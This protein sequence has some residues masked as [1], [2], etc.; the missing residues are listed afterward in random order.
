MSE[1]TMSILE[2]LE[3]LR[4][5]LLISILSLVPASAVGWYYREQL[6]ALLTEPVKALDQKLVYLAMTEAFMVELKLAIIAGFI[7]A[8]PV[9]FWQVWSFILPALQTHERRYLLVMVPLSVLLFC[10]GIVFGYSTVFRFGL[11][12]FLGFA[13]EGLTP[14]LSLSKYLTF[15]F[16]FLLPFGLM[17]ELPLVMFFLAKIGIVNYR[18]LAKNRK[19][20][21][22]IIFIISAVAT[23]TTDL[24]TQAAMAIPM[25]VLFEMSIWIVRFVRP[26]SRYSEEWN[27]ENGGAAEADDK[28]ADA[29]NDDTSRTVSGA[30]EE[31]V[32]QDPESGS[33]SDRVNA[34]DKEQRLEEIYRKI[35]ERGNPE[36]KENDG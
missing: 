36:K 25:Y 18:F 15:T 11:K 29:A 13:T 16:W 2:H 1:K 35:T 20:A 5:V 33:D 10:G 6:L 9:I 17:F 7:L 23:P 22:L 21:L 8:S 28:A 34:D 32:E 12:F 27:G 30:A 31:D 19:F 14:M 24:V 4:R 3:D 26:R